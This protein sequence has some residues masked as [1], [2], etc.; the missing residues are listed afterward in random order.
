MKKPTKIIRLLKK[1][2]HLSIVLA[3]IFSLGI[4]TF[5]SSVNAQMLR[6][7]IEENEKTYE[8]FI[9]DNPYIPDELEKIIYD[10]IQDLYKEVGTH[11]RSEI[12]LENEK[13]TKEIDELLELAQTNE[14]NS[15]LSDLENLSNNLSKLSKK[16]PLLQVDKEKI[17]DTLATIKNVTEAYQ[18]KEELKNTYNDLHA[19]YLE[20]SKNQELFATD[21]HSY[22]DKLADTVT[23]AKEISKFSH[24]DNDIKDS[25]QNTIK[26]AEKVFNEKEYRLGDF[27][28]YYT[29]L[30][31]LVEEAKTKEEQGK[32]EAE[33]KARLAAEQARKKAE[34]ETRKAQE[35][36]QKAQEAAQ[37][38][39][40]EQA[41]QASS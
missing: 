23:K 39:A 16:T 24:I 4:A 11:K 28:N 14:V 22:K 7:Q 32:K 38:I 13:L 20:L 36:A 18:S 9:Q 3:S 29:Q 27:E 35:E 5:T 8:E 17:N 41:N 40:Q 6:I 26:S 30:H 2:I 31:R 21:T 1:R 10:E 25:A 37:R 19:S 12:R 33:E 34:E 15:H